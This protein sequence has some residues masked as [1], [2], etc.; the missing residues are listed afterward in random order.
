MYV[1]EIR[2]IPFFL[3]WYRPGSGPGKRQLCYHF[4]SY[5]ACNLQSRFNLI[6]RIYCLTI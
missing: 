3:I 2:I 1:F 6:F 5:Q 4:K